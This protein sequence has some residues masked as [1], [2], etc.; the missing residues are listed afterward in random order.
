[1]LTILAMFSLRAGYKLFKRS[2]LENDKKTRVLIIGAGDAGY[3][4][5]KELEQYENDKI[6]IV[7][8]VDDYKNGV[9]ISGKKF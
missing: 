7:G 2:A 1:M 3:I 5:L 9:I 4:L 8:F 6:D